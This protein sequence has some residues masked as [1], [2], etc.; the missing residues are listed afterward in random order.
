VPE[1]QPARRRHGLGLAASVLILLGLVVAA[2]NLHAIAVA[3]VPVGVEEDLGDAIVAEAL[4]GP[5]P[6]ADP[7]VTAFVED[8]GARLLAARPEQPYDFTFHVVDDPGLNAFAAPGGEVIVLTGLVAAAGS[9]GEVAGVLAHELAHVFERHV[10]RQLVGQLGAAAA[11]SLVFGSGE[12][13]DVAA[14][15]SLAGLRF[16]RAHE[17]DA[18][19]AGA[20][21]LHDAGLD[22]RH[23]AAFFAR[24]AALEAARGGPPPAFLATHP[25][26]EER[27]RALERLASELPPR[28]YEELD[29][30]WE[31]LRDLARR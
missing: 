5:A 15:I 13:D 21:L 11:L 17:A 18:D 3:L 27:A 31:R 8:V 7:E 10:V 28:D 12:L 30:D 9:P 20:R 6:A 29:V 24:V 25:P 19:A 2:F 14:G 1:N 26:S 16:S 22:P 4:A 23:L